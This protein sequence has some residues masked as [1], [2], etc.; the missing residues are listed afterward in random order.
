[1]VVRV[2]FRAAIFGAQRAE[3]EG[4]TI[5]TEEIDVYSQIHG[6]RD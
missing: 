5:H 6:T 1:M 4:A 3:C 2:A